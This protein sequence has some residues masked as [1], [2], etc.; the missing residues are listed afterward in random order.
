LA[1]QQYRSDLALKID[2]NQGPF[3]F[4][5]AFGTYYSKISAKNLFCEYANLNEPDTVLKIH[6]QYIDA[7]AKAIKTNTF[8]VN[9][10]LTKNFADITALIQSGYELA[11]QAAE[12]KALVFA[13]IG[14]IN[15]VKEDLDE[16]YVQLA[17]VFI[18]C[19]AKYF[20][21]ETLAE[22]EIIKPAILHIKK[23][24]PDAFILVSFAVL[25][26]GY[27]TKGYYY[28]NLI[29]AAAQNK[30]VDAVGLNCICGPSHLLNLIKEL[31]LKDITFSAMPNSGYP[32]FINNRTVYEDNTEYFSEKLNDIYKLGVKIIGGCCGTTPE[33]IKAI[34]GKL[35]GE[36]RSL[37]TA[38]NYITT[39]EPTKSPINLF[40]KKMLAGEKIIAVEIN[41]P[42][43]NNCD[44]LLNAA[45]KARKT[46]ADI[47][48]LA[49]SPLARARA[50]SIMMAAKIKREID[51]NVLPHLC[52][53]DR[54]HIGIKAALLGASIEGINNIL[55]VTGDPVAQTDR[56]FSKGV[57]SFNSFNL[58]AYINNLNTEL[59]AERPFFIG[60]ALNVNANRFDNELKRARRKIENGAEFLLSQPIFSDQAAANF[61]TA[62][63][64]LDCKILAG[65]LPV[66]GYKNALFLNNEVS[67]IDIP[68]AVLN[69]L[70]DKTPEQTMEISV[71]YS[72]SII[73]KIADFCDGYY[74]ST[75]L[76]KIDLVCSLINQVK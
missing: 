63:E 20:L 61:A 32:S 70:K 26:D 24:V 22:Y 67:G 74:F 48:T 1:A 21:F 13:D 69:N 15:S 57:F 55:V 36:K 6:K 18:D 7:G 59:F 56:S 38:E 2:F 62:K 53:R 31:N 66:A 33:H 46:G 51:I 3:L 54:N 25:Q 27:T 16:E 19:G 5:G 47:I 23:M 8:G 42:L 4:D 9:S 71:N 58:I 34:A 68:D 52:C 76:K 11:A 41:P 50:D 12:N 28:K 65:I 60:G 14:Y 75:P 72:M 39:T 73:E 10:N 43:D 64:C 37:T 17:Q 45:E 30:Y 29:S 44:Y 35:A 40:K 49:D